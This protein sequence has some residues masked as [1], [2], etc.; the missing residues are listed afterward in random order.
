M[1]L[2]NSDAT[3]IWSFSARLAGFGMMKY[4]K[5]ATTEG[6]NTETM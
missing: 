4:I 5:A 3:V 6:A 1:G 2:L